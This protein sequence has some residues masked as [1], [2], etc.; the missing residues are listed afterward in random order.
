MKTFDN[1][2]H[3]KEGK[4]MKKLIIAEDEALE[5]KALQFIIEKHLNRDVEIVAIAC[6]GLEA[7]AKVKETKADIILLDINMPLLDGLAAAE[8]MKA[9]NRDIEIII[10]TAFNKF[11]F[12][13]KGIRL[14]IN[15]YLLKPVSKEELIKAINKTIVKIEERIDTK[16]VYTNIQKKMKVLS[17]HIKGKFILDGILG[18]EVSNEKV[19]EYKNIFR[20]KNENFRCIIFNNINIEKSEKIIKKIE[21]E[22]SYHNLLSISYFHRDKIIIMVFNQSINQRNML[23][24]KYIHGILTKLVKT[25]KGMDNDSISIGVSSTINNLY[26]INKAYN[27]ANS[28]L[29]KKQDDINYYLDKRNLQIKD[30][31]PYHIEKLICDYILGNKRDGAIN[32][33]NKIYDYIVKNYNDEREIK[34]YILRFYLA[35]T[36]NLAYKLPDIQIFEYESIEKQINDLKDINSIKKYMHRIIEETISV[37]HS[38]DDSK[39]SKAIK[40]AKQYIRDNYMKEISLNDIA[41]YVNLSPYYFSRLFKK[42]E[43]INFK[44]YLI[45]VRMEEA[46]KLL[47]DWTV[48]IKEV[49]SLVGYTDPNY[50]SRAFKKYTGMSASDYANKIT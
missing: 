1:T 5:R 32:E 19:N 24:K 10:I 13:Q 36:R 37:L 6:N 15:E 48:S 43:K 21:S 35:L 44:E 31:Y 9:V 20:I 2:F 30:E 41:D 28:V 26:Q 3:Y 39:E 12:A 29:Y 8:E 11:E 42:S 7:I 16:S 46:K 14:G 22:L 4:D 33:F 38:H 25:I 18:N 45:K 49:A 17:P 50:F 47:S 23:E 40:I 27:E 34:K